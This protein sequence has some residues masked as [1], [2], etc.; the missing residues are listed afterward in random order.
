MAVKEVGGEGRGWVARE[1]KASQTEQSH[2]A[3]GGTAELSEAE[4]NVVGVRH[5]CEPGRDGRG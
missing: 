2:G 5:H 4:D 1:A 3:S